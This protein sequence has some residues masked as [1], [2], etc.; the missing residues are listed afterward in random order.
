MRRDD[1]KTNWMGGV[2]QS[3]KKMNMRE[4][5]DGQMDWRRMNLGAISSSR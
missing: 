2:Q 5:R 4:A 3:K 1:Q